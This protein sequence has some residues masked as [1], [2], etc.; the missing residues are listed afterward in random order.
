MRI[1]I[2]GNG[3]GGVFPLNYRIMITSMIK[4]AIETSDEQYFEELYLFEGK[5]NKKI[6]PFSF[7]VYFR[8]YIIKSDIVQVN[9]D[10]SIIISTPDYNLGIAL[11]NGLLRMKEYTFN[12]NYTFIKRKVL[13]QKESVINNSKVNFK[14][15]SPI[16]IKGKDNKPIDVSSDGYEEELN[17]ISNILLNSYRG[18]GLKEKLTFTPINMKKMV[19]KEKIKDFMINC[20]KEYIYISAYSGIFA[21]EGD[22][23]DLQLLMQ[24]GLGFRRSEGFGLIDL[25]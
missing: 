25:V 24:L 12:N 15:L 7:G 8:D 21:L 9:G 6:K 20:N 13:L 19:I 11:Y 5:K 16:H 2:M 1:R 14:T 23:E 17:Y 22:V 18:Y 10:I 4:K 3:A